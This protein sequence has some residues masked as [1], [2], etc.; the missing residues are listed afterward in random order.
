M[1]DFVR[2]FT[3]PTEVGEGGAPLS[4]S[5]ALGAY[6]IRLPVATSPLAFKYQVSW[7][8]RRTAGETDDEIGTLIKS[9]NLMTRELATGREQIALS[10]NMLKNQNA[11]PSILSVQCR[12]DRLL[13]R[14]V[15][16]L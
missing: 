2:P 9:F 16:L 1:A 15:H 10:G 6:A 5:G 4:G 14:C 13:P 8:C 12:W 3:V 7:L 11:V